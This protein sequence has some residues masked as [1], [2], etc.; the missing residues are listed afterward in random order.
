MKVRFAISLLLLLTVGAVSWPPVSFAPGDHFHDPAASA[1]GE[2]RSPIPAAV[3]E[4]RNLIPAAHAGADAV[5]LAGETVPFWG[6]GAS[7]EYEIVE[8]MWDFDGDGVNDFVSRESGHTTFTF[9]G[10]GRYQCVLTVVDSEGQTARDTRRIVVVADGPAA[11][12]A[13]QT[14]APARYTVRNAADGVTHRYAVMINGGSE[15]RFWIDVEVG[16][17]M[18]VN[19]YGFSPDDVYLLNYRGESYYG[20]NPD[21][22]IDY[23]ARLENV[24]SVFAELAV[25]T[26]ED[27][28]VF[29]W[30]TDH[31][32]GYRGPE[33]QYYGYLA[34]YASVD[35]GDEPD[36]LE[37]EFRLRTF[38]TG[39]DYAEVYNHGMNVWAPY[40]AYESPNV[41]R[42]Y[43]RKYVSHFDSVYVESA[44]EFFSDDDVYIEQFYDYALGDTNRDGRIDANIGEVYDFDGDGDPPYDPAD[45]TYDEDDWGAV[46]IMSDDYNYLSTAMPEGGYPYK[47]FDDGLQGKLCIDLA[48]AGGIPE[49]DGRDED[50]AG[51]FDWMDVNMDGDTEDTVSIDELVCLYIDELS[52]DDLAMFVDRLSVAKITTVAMPCYSG[53]LIEDLSA[54]NHGISTATTEEDASSGNGFIRDFTAALHGFDQYGIPVDADA[55]ENGYVS[56]TEAFNYAAPRNSYLHIPQYDDN[57]D[58]IPQEAP[59]PAGGDGTFGASTYLCDIG[60]ETVAT[61][62]IDPDGGFYQLSK[63]VYITC[64]TPGAVIR[65][66][67]DNSD[68]KPTSPEYMGSILVDHRMVL[69]AR[70]YKDGCLPS[71]VA[72]AAFF[73]PGNSIVFVKPDGDDINDGSSWAAAKRTI[74]G[75]LDV[76]SAGD[77]VW[78]KGDS[79]AVYAERITVPV[80][81]AMY[82]GFGGGESDPSE[83]YSFPREAGD[84]LATIIDG[85]DGG[86]VVTIEA[87]A[88]A[89]TL[90]DGLTIRNGFAAMGGGVYIDSGSPTVLRC[91]VTGNFATFYGGGIYCNQ[92]SDPAIGECRVTGNESVY[93]GGGIQ[94][95]NGSS[96]VVYNSIVAENSAGTYGGGLFLWASSSLC[97]PRLINCLIANN[98]AGQYGAGVVSR[99]MSNLEMINCTVA[100]NT[101]TRGG[102][103]YLEECASRIANCI[104]RYNDA[105]SY[106]D[107]IKLALGAELTVS[108]TA[109]PAGYPSV[110]IDGDC[111][112]AWGDGCIDADPLFTDPDGPDDDPVTSADNDYRLLVDSPCIDAGDNDALPG[113][114]ATD[115]DGC[116]RLIDCIYVTPDPGHGAP[117]V[118]DMGACEWQYPSNVEAEPFPRYV[119]ALRQNYPNPFNP[120]TTVSFSVAKRGRVAIR[121][122]DVSGRLVRTLTDA[123]YERGPHTVTWDG[124]NENGRRVASGVYLYCMETG[125]VKRMKKMV[126]IR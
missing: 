11:E 91:T 83:R 123:I 98:T 78:V 25:R 32:R 23:E 79:G 44:D 93:C 88:S 104:F 121:I 71:A 75:A 105:T 24:D 33:D 22:M 115:V 43:R 20:D 51:L 19:G 68:P 41:Y 90:I 82:G 120:L 81:V 107:N 124:V 36:Y 21:G 116:P 64:P 113:G 108:Y 72:E 67:T 34:G 40:K 15:E 35:P 101:A 29:I 26:D 2:V 102:G 5:V 50:N 47:I 56:M 77:D 7:P 38:I 12:R 28:E 97:T 10:T 13:R 18:L 112:L 61:P 48:Y 96:P 27:D 126:L 125:A 16:Y 73:M 122:Y 45:S 100:G 46:D 39:G 1:V 109:V 3:R 114:L 85:G 87:G 69:K 119:T 52:D 54:A 89:V 63:Y 70:A 30:I 103:L 37:S 86:T 4:V 66:T 99:D 6:N 80:D 59:V 62:G 84:S 53:G 14:L 65:Y 118:V 76:V 111:V 9:Y 58:G 106:A 8:Y 117:P 31:G 95:S 17:D 60:A 42:F 92:Y 57:G 74:A 110:H 55:D 49:I 94:S